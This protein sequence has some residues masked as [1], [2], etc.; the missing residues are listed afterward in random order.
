[1]GRSKFAKF[2]Q[3]QDRDSAAGVN[4]RT[5]TNSISGPNP[6]LPVQN[7]D[8]LHSLAGNGPIGGQPLMNPSPSNLSMV[9]SINGQNILNPLA[10]GPNAL[11]GLLANLNMNGAASVNKGV[12]RNQAVGVPTGGSI[13]GI[14]AALAAS[15]P[16]GNRP[17]SGA[18]F[19]QAPKIPQ[20][21]S[22][23]HFGTQ[24]QLH[25]Q[26][27][28]MPHIP[29]PNTQLP[30]NP[31]SQNDLTDGGKFVPNGMV[32]GL[33]PPRRDSTISGGSDLDERDRYG[34]NLQR[35]PPQAQ[36][37]LFEQQQLNQ[38][39]SVPQPMYPNQ[40]PNRNGMNVVPPQFRHGPS[41]IGNQNPT[42]NG[43]QHQ[44][45]MSSMGGIIRPNPQEL[46][47]NGG[48]AGMVGMGL[49]VMRGMGSGI[50]PDVIRGPHELGLRGGPQD[51]NGIPGIMRSPSDVP[52]PFGM[53][54][55]QFGGPQ[56]LPGQQNSL[57]PNHI[58]TGPTAGGP[59]RVGPPGSADFVLHTQQL[60][61]ARAAAAA[62]QQQ[63]MMQHLGL[64][65][66]HPNPQS[67]QQPQQLRPGLPQHILPH[68]V[69]QQQQLGGL[70][71]VGISQL[72]P[73]DFGGSGFPPHANHVGGIG[74]NAPGAG[75]EAFLQLFMN[76]SGQRE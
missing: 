39:R 69:N 70:N 54:Q 72:H 62:Q 53:A 49:P 65:L 6:S 27:L 33:G 76:G 18:G 5:P 32:P 45:G 14:F 43:S 28:Q 47:G 15:K 59:V 3:S 1:M 36:Q 71:Q 11:S 25:P 22:P 13:E 67:V 23:H 48:G 52:G 51:L 7:H 56:Q 12:D 16:S 60:Q 9:D 2:F 29:P 44:R 10:Q 38:L 73:N 64:G 68:N 31:S 21:Q 19:G 26:Q 4:P 8:P 30:F 58:L 66:R 41:P 61:A 34:F 35:L 63:Q 40:G 74:P 75:A 57:P 20:S 37:Q 17:P 42:S 24:H 50:G 55:Q 46:V